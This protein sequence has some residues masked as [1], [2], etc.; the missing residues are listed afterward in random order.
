MAESVLE[1]LGKADEIIVQDLAQIP[2]LHRI[3]SP[4]SPF[5]VAHERLWPPERSRALGLGH[6]RL[7]THAL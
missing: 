6:P 5:H 3:Q 2:Q 7:N 1:G 4:Y